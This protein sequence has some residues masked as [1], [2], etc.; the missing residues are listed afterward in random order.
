MSLTRFCERKHVRLPAN[1]GLH[2]ARVLGNAV[3][4]D[5][6]NLFPG[7]HAVTPVAIDAERKWL[8]EPVSDGDLAALTDTDLPRIQNVFAPPTGLVLDGI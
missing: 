7:A 1:A 5:Q 3:L 8:V 4:A 6:A 2:D